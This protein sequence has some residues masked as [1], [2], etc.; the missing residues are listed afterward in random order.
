MKSVAQI[1]PHEFIPV[2][3]GQFSRLR[4][5][6]GGK[7]TSRHPKVYPPI[8]STISNRILRF[9]LKKIFLAF[10]YA[11]WLLPCLANGQPASISGLSNGRP[12]VY[13]DFDGHFVRGTSWNWDSAIHAAPSGLSQAAIDEILNRVTEDYR[14]FEIDIVIDSII[15]ENAPLEKRLRVIITP[16]HNWYGNAGGVAFVGSFIWGDDTPAWV[17]NTLLENNPKYIAESISHEIGHTLGLQHQSKYNNNNCQ[18]IAEYYEGGG[19]GEVGWAPIMGASY[20]KNLSVWHYGTSIEGCSVIQNDIAIIT[21]GAHGLK[22]RSDDHGNTAQDATPLALYSSLIQSS[23]IINNAAD[24][25]VFSFN[26]QSPSTLH[27]QAIPYHVADNN[28]GANLDIKLSLVKNGTDTLDHY[29]PPQFL[30]AA[31]DTNLAAGSYLLVVDGVGNNYITDYGIVG[32]YTL[33]GS[34][35]ITLPVTRLILT[36]ETVNNEHQL[37]WSF[38]ADEPVKE[39]A[40]EISH[41]GIV[42]T[43]LTAMHPA[44]ASFTNQ[45][46]AGDSGNRYYRVKLITLNG[47][48]A[49]YSNIISL[50]HRPGADISLSGNIIDQTIRLNVRVPSAYRLSDASGRLLAQGTLVPGFHHLPVHTA[51]KG[52]LFLKIF[53]SKDQQVFKLVKQ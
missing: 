14:I 25:D 37:K 10:I 40:I 38:M 7:L 36:G 28:S 17:F 32:Y 45:V 4:K 6:R 41:D 44:V 42:F 15:Y 34:L 12:T 22:M 20:Y 33:Q 18:L 8:I 30:S 46:A 3:P 2:L 23:G 49:Y 51:Q 13:L 53:N 9:G 16:T 1:Q 47:E 29:N 11:V 26:I 21:Q 52:L 5:N 19:S 27:I 48:R 39:A 43:Q 35:S 31:I 24:R 50:Q